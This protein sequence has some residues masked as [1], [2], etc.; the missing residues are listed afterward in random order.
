MY[1]QNNDI[2]RIG[3]MGRILSLQYGWPEGISELDS[4]VQRVYE[5]ES[6]NTSK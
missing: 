2:L 1:D 3:A 6:E 4:I 5:L